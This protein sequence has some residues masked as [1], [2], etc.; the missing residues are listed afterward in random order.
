M[1][2]LE[3][4]LRLDREGDRDRGMDRDRGGDRDRGDNPDRERDRN[5]QVPDQPSSGVDGDRNNP[6]R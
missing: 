4:R 2:A 1:K 5:D 3:Y 6:S